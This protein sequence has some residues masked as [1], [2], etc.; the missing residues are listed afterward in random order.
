LLVVQRLAL[1]HRVTEAAALGRGF[2][3]EF[4]AP[5]PEMH[6]EPTSGVLLQV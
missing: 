3:F 6:E 4:F 1:I 2:S 5:F